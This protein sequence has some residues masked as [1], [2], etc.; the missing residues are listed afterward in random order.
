MYENYISCGY[1]HKPT[2]EDPR[3]G[4]GAEMVLYNP[5]PEPCWATMTVYYEDKTP[6]TLKPVPVKPETNELVVMPPLA[7]EAFT[8]CGF[9]GLKVLS[10]TPLML[11]FIDGIFI[12]GAERRFSGGCTNFHGTKLHREWYLCDCLW[13]EWNKLYKGDLSKAPFPFNEL[14]YYHILNPNPRPAEVEM[15]LRFRDLPWQ[16]MRFTIPP[17]RVWAW[18][19][20]DQVPYCKNYTLKVVSTEPVSLSATRYIYDLTGFEPWGMT[21]HGSMY[22]IPGPVTE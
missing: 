8:D 5:S 22:G 16:T 20:L 13:L 11:N 7:P 1:S 3:I 21:V 12:K 6:I 9:W 2:A 19:N 14:E 4:W 17:E 10:T 18:N 15:V